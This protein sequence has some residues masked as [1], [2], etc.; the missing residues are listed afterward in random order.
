MN[1][2]SPYWSMVSR[3]YYY[4]W[5]YG[6]IRSRIQPYINNQFEATEIINGLWLGSIS[7]SSNRHHLQQ[8]GIKTILS[9]AIGIEPLY[10]SDF[11]YLQI[12]LLDTNEKLQ[13]I[14]DEFLP[15]IHHRLT[16]NKNILIHCIVGASRSAS[17]VLAYL[18]K[19][20]GYSL[21][22]ALYFVQQKRPVVNPNPYYIQQLKLFEQTLKPTLSPFPSIHNTNNPW[23][24]NATD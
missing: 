4:L 17:L 6:Q 12:P 9:V 22:Q 3:N 20:H 15:I 21:T 5:V 24:N 16:Q 2:I 7:S 8:L 19:Y 10:P 23:P 13:P 1:H 18:I 11:E 14:F